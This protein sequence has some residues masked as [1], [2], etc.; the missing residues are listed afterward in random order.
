MEFDV[1]AGTGRSY[2]QDG[3]PLTAWL[4]ESTI[5]YHPNTGMIKQ[6]QT[7]T[8]SEYYKSD[9]SLDYYTVT[10]DS[11]Y[12]EFYNN[13][14]LKNEYITLENGSRKISRWF[15]NGQLQVTGILEN[16]VTVG[17][18]IRYDSLGNVV[19]REIYND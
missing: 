1:D 15:R 12:R 18:W 13:N 14:S 6:I 8:Q 19:E 4:P 17:E 3:R 10:D 7:A 9:G 16:G 2:S 5:E 11:T